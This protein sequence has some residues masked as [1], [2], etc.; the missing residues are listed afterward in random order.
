MKVCRADSY[1]V[2]PWKNGGGSTTEVAISPEGAS[3]DHFDWRISMARIE[4]AGPF[5]SFPGIDRTL[6]LLD[7]PRVE[8]RV[9]DRDIALSAARPS[10]RF[11]GE[12]RVT[13]AVPEGPIVDFNV[14]TRRARCRH[15]FEQVEIAGER[16]LTHAGGT[17]ILFL[18]EGGG[19]ACHDDAGRSAELE[20]RDCLLLTQGD[21]R[22]WRLKS[23]KPATVCVVA[24]LPQV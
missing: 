16:S 2:M 14:M 10:L 11:A 1:I 20:R 3:L 21:A 8:L 13:A 19:L 4:R 15:R 9:G 24:L 23:D 6:T 7:G 22:D 18:A 12:D 5:S 17:T